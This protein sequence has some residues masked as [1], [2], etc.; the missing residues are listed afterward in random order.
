[1]SDDFRKIKTE[2]ELKD[3][4]LSS[5]REAFTGEETSRWIVAMQEESVSQA[6]E[7]VVTGSS[8]NKLNE[9]MAAIVDR[10]FDNFKRY[11]FEFNRSL[12]QRELVVNCERPASMRTQADYTDMGDPIRFCI[13]HISSRDWALVVQAEENRVRAFIAPIKYL[14][15]FQPDQR[16][17]EPYVDIKLIRDKVGAMR[18]MVW[19]ID[20]QA[21]AFESIP[22]LSRRLFG[23]LV[24]VTRGEATNTEKFV[25]D[26]HEYKV[27]PNDV[28]IERSYEP[29]DQNMFFKEAQEKNAGQL[30]PKGFALEKERTTHTLAALANVGQNPSPFLS[31]QQIQHHMPVASSQQSN[32]DQQNFVPQQLP[33]PMPQLAQPS[34]GRE[35][36]TQDQA[37]AVSDN[38][39]SFNK[40][41]LPYRPEP[42]SVEQFASPAA[43]PRPV[44]EQAPFDQK[45]LFE[46]LAGGHSP[47]Q[48]SGQAQA[49]EAPMQTASPPVFSQ[50]QQ[51]QPQVQEKSQAQAQAETTQ[52]PNAASILAQRHNDSQPVSTSTQQAS[53]QLAS[54]QPVPTQTPSAQTPSA[55]LAAQPVS[56]DPPTTMPAVAYHFQAGAEGP[57]GAAGKVSIEKETAENNRK[58]A[59]ALKGLF[60]SVDSSISTLNALGVEA[61]NADDI[62][63]VSNVMKQVKTLKVLRDGIVQLSKDWQKSIE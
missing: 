61:M 10:F 27:N 28:A 2:E 54:T 55:Q 57:N 49:H 23:Q 33:L 45:D 1:M 43:A 36:D 4:I 58:V 52:I 24:K 48:N 51:P 3:K 44:P 35:T 42:Q 12:D 18:Q 60:D 20:G 19:S 41:E 63:A 32:T 29:D 9:N 38:Q 13:G 31:H 22:A 11:A 26:P 6:D 34:V 7:S 53:A 40:N 16:D 25:F 17:F 5:V 46:K 62:Q 37:D 15:G 39:N 59:H 47:T 30:A 14:V 50:T 56:L 8:D 21:L